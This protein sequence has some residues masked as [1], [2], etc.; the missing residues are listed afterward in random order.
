MCPEMGLGVV[1]LQ[2]G[3]AGLL[4]G[5]ENLGVADLAMRANE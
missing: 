1:G 5:A 2:R 4:P 3:A